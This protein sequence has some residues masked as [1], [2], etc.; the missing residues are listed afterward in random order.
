MRQKSKQACA[1]ILCIVLVAFNYSVAYAF[2][3]TNNGLSS[4]MEDDNR[5]LDAIS[6]LLE[7]LSAKSTAA[8]EL[9]EA[10]GVFRELIEFTT[11][12]RTGRVEMGGVVR[13]DQSG[14]SCAFMATDRISVQIIARDENG[15]P[16]NVS[17]TVHNRNGAFFFYASQQNQ[18]SS[19]F[20]LSKALEEIRTQ[21]DDASEVNIP[22][23]RNNSNAP[24][25]ER[26]ARDTRTASVEYK[27]DM[28]RRVT[29]I[30]V[31]Q[32]NGW[33]LQL[34]HIGSRAEARMASAAWYNFLAARGADN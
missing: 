6:A 10:G 11:D 3:E 20:E 4:A 34:R 8:I 5:Q 15:R 27:G 22:N 16:N 12:G 23:I 25:Y 26:I 28:G 9:A 19:E 32:R 21:H 17:C 29:S 1:S 18:S 31:T 13:H 33:T 14:L 24:P 30:F 2:A 7:R